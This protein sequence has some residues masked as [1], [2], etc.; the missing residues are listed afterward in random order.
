[1]L[2]LNRRERRLFR[3]SVFAHGLGALGVVFFGFLP[4]CRK[5][6]EKVHVFELAA[7]APL[8]EQAA[9]APQPPAPP[10][11]VVTPPPKPPPPQVIPP[12]PPKVPPPPPPKKTTPKKK[13]PKKTTP[14]KKVSFNDF[15]KDRPQPAP[16]KPAPVRPKPAPRIDATKYDLPKIKLKESP[17]NASPS[18]PASVLNRYLAQVKAKMQRVWQGLESST[19]LGFGGEASLS[20]RISSNGSIIS[21]RLSRTSGNRALDQ[22][23]LRV[24]R[25]VGNVGRPPGG[26]L[27]SELELNF[28]AN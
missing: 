2:G 5:E 1:M 14:K 25:S 18:V 13:V 8:P 12:P 28:S 9:P 21:A 17:G 16:V 22:L 20:F 26:K 24:G 11:P 3:L 7:A 23:V 27:D 19:D 6:P 10:P 15:I 4:S